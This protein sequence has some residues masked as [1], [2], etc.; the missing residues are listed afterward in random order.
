MHASVPQGC[1][2]LVSDWATASSSLGAMPVAGQHSRGRDAS[3]RD[4]ELQACEPLQRRRS[5]L[6]FFHSSATVGSVAYRVKI[7]GA[8]KPGALRDKLV[9]NMISTKYPTPRPEQKEEKETIRQGL[10][11]ARACPGLGAIIRSPFVYCDRSR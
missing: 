4:E 6:C 7:D 11:Q 8:K 5:Q 10:V 3:L 1:S 9:R 2:D